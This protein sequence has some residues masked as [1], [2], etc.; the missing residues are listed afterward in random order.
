M[1]NAVFWCLFAALAAAFLAGGTAG[2]KKSSVPSTAEPAYTP[3]WDVYFVGQDSGRP[4]YWKNGDRTMLAPAGL[5]QGIAVSG[6][7]VYVG[8]G[9][10]KAV[11]S[12]I[13]NLAALWK[14]G[15]EED[16]TDTISSWAYTPVLS[17]GN[18]YVPGYIDQWGGQ[19]EAVYWKNGQPVGLDSTNWATATGIAVNGSDVYVL[20]FT[21]GSA[22]DS[23]VVWEN[24]Q[25]LAGANSTFDQPY[26]QMLVSNGN[27]YVAE[28]QGYFE[29]FA[30]QY[31]ALPHAS[32]AEC[33]LLNGSDIY[34]AGSRVDSAGNVWAAY[35]KNGVM[36]TLANYP[37]TTMSNAWSI[38]IAGSDVY[39]AG[40]A[41]VNGALW[42]VF[43][44]NGAEAA[45][46]R[47]GA[48]YGAAVA[49]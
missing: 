18:V 25:V 29:N 35:W 8:G 1:K 28:L 41:F 21:G 15:V 23:S 45:P 20:G 44:K 5:G 30:S 36:D 4:V 12:E 19:P 48:I 46:S 6:S 9:V 37:G 16:L 10:T 43:W 34:V 11:H 7:D 39:V 14:N 42:G 31:T 17:G 33:L 38:V 24:D 22:I 49:N 32:S 40:V 13:I 3:G 26:N 27:I 2:C 47:N